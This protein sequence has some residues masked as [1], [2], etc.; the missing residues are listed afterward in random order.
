MKPLVLILLLISPMALAQMPGQPILPGQQ[1]VNNTGDPLSE[2]YQLTLTVSD[3]E[4]QVANLSLAVGSTTFQATS[5][6]PTINF[7]G[8][9]K[10]Q[11]NG[12]LLVQ[13]FL[14]ASIEV[15]RY[16]QN[17]SSTSFAQGGSSGTIRLQLDKPI[18][19]LK[20]GSRSYILTVSQTEESGKE[21]APSK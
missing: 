13:Y 4:K 7:S 9:F 14:S 5:A 19:I 17:G 3:K 10:P 21:V 11:K 15:T 20:D 2:N 8:S 18:T 16:Q 1:P 12:T 6:D